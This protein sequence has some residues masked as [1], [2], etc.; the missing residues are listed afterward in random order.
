MQTV[1]PKIATG[2]PH[3][4]WIEFGKLYEKHGKCYCSRYTRSLN[5][6][7]VFLQR[8]IVSFSPLSS[9]PHNVLGDLA[10]ARAVFDRAVEV[11]F[12]NVDD[13][14]SV[15]CE[16]AEMEIRN[17]YVTSIIN[18]HLNSRTD[19]PAQACP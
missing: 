4:L 17:G 13:L 10:Q 12:R 19:Q 3:Q 9:V 8:K 5:C 6:L 2:H 11:P 16:Y 18:P 7:R 15:W 1:D 14:A